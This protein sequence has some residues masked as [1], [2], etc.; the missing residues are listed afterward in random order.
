MP[1]SLNKICVIIYKKIEYGIQNP[2]AGISTKKSCELDL[3]DF[4]LASDFYIQYSRL[5]FKLKGYFYGR[6]K[7]T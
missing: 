2:E 7:S 5:Q 6:T 1:P 4:L 3:H